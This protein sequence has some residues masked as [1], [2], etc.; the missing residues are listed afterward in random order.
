L[1]R[2]LLVFN[3]QAL[4][5][6]NCLNLLARGTT[7]EVHDPV[8]FQANKEALF[9][10]LGEYELVLIRAAPPALRTIPLEAHP[11]VVQVPTV[12]FH[13]YHPDFCY[14]ADTGPL[15]RGAT[16]HYHS[17][18]AYAAFQCGLDEKATSAL[19]NRRVYEQLGYFDAWDV[20]RE[21]ML[22]N[23]AKYDLDIGQAFVDWSRNGP[24][25][26]TLNHPR[27]QVLRDIAR[28]ILARAGVAVAGT[29]FLPHDNLANG[30]C[31]PV[32]P[33]IGA[34]LGVEGDY[35]F[36]SGASYRTF[37]LD[38]YIARSF[39]AYR[40]DPGAKPTNQQYLPTLQRAI[41]YI[42]TR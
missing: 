12:M 31:L 40:E 6:G 9:A 11:S 30:P 3:C 29:S 7:V 10:G 14:L 16:G 27:I 34:R 39:A 4:G 23:Y 24:F 26:Y 1:N 2:W 20:E 33:E 5:L 41:D 18:I 32:Y 21:R 42:S 15:S 35:F 13:G 37:D 22:A 17:A 8:S 36:K 28:I 38:E 19:F 25:M